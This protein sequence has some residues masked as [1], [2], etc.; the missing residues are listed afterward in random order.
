MKKCRSRSR[1]FDQGT[2]KIGPWME[3]TRK[4]AYI[5]VSRNGYEYPVC[6]EHV[7]DIRDDFRFKR[8]KKIGK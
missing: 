4:T 2:G 6:V 7:R 1:D 5:A 8:V 3:C